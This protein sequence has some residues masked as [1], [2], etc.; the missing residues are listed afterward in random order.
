MQEERGLFRE[1]TLSRVSI[2]YKFIN[3]E[4]HSKKL[5]MERKNAVKR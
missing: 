4:T 2:R 1:W 3:S 5:I